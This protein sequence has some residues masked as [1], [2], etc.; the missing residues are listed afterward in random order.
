MPPLNWTIFTKVPGWR[1]GAVISSEDSNC[2]FEE[3]IFLNLLKVCLHGPR[4]W[5]RV[6]PLARRSVIC[7]TF[8]GFSGFDCFCYFCP[9]SRLSFMLLFSI[10]VG[11]H[12]VVGSA[13][14]ISGM[15]HIQYFL[16][17]TILLLEWA[18][19][20]LGRP[21]G[22][23]RWVVLSALVVRLSN[24]RNIIP[25]LTYVYVLHTMAIDHL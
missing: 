24:D 13:I 14:L 2:P 12:I 3:S 16:P 22:E 1:I 23:V 5:F 15:W 11:N 21:E 17:K 25:I 19:S 18:P 6:D 9:L 7:S 20:R 10:L 4:G 8:L